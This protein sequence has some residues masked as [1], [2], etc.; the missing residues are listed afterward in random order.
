MAKSGCVGG[1]GA[2]GE[3]K[4]GVWSSIEFGSGVAESAGRASRRAPAGWAS[5]QSLLSR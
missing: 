5:H 3:S 1:L 2:G 4:A